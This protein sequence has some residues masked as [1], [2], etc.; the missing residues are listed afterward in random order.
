MN[1][2]YKDLEKPCYIEMLNYEP[3]E[4]KRELLEHLRGD[5]RDAFWEG[6]VAFSGCQTG[7]TALDVLKF[8]G[9]GDL[10]DLRFESLTPSLVN[11]KIAFRIME[12]MEKP[13]HREI[14]DSLFT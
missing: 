9:I 1:F 4:L 12:E 7:E 6:M 11:L 10:R 13:L 3:E 5:E 2:P 14:K 8:G